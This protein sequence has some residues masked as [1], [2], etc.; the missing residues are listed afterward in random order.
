MPINSIILIIVLILILFLQISLSKKDNSKLGLVL[1]TLTFAISIVAA[2]NVYIPE[3]N[4]SSAIALILS[5]FIYFNIPT[6]IFYGI[7]LYY[8]KYIKRRNEIERMK[9]NDL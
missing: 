4:F 2:L 1:P 9:I 6:V 5:V 7:Y 8:K 3:S